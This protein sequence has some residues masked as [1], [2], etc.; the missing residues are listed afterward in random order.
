MATL[1]DGSTK[2]LFD[3]SSSSQVENEEA[4]MMVVTLLRHCNNK[5]GIIL[6][7]EYERLAES[8]HDHL[9]RSNCAS[10]SSATTYD[11]RLTSLCIF[12]TQMKKSLN[13]FK[14]GCKAKRDDERYI[15]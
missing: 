10:T 6:D 1:Q 9:V 4:C 3:F 12:V 11:L 7:L 8:K 2:S 14:Q 5:V 13:R 15:L